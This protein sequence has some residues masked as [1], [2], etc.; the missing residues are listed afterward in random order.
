[1]QTSP[2]TL[3]GEARIAELMH[4]Y[5]TAEYR[6]ELDGRWL[7]LRIGAPTPEVWARFPEAA[8]AGLLSAWNPCSVPRSEAAN[9]EADRHLHRDLIDTGL[10]IRAAFCSATNRTWR[11]PSWL[12]LGMSAAAFDAL[13]RRYEQ[14]A[15]LFWTPDG[16]IRLRVDA[17]RPANFLDD[18]RIDWLR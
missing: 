3:L 17:A 7:D 12:V 14:L 8:C 18:R 16:S 5:L 11:E 6:W 15:T 1:M 4:A 2:P 9:R 10:P 13:S